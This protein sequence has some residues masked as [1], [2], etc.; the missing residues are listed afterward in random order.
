MLLIIKADLESKQG[1]ANGVNINSMLY[2]IFSNS[3]QSNDIC[4]HILW[5]KP[6]RNEEYLLRTVLKLKEVIIRSNAMLE[7]KY[8]DANSKPPS[9][10]WQIHW[11]LNVNTTLSR[12]TYTVA[13]VVSWPEWKKDIY[14]PCNIRLPWRCTSI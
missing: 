9:P 13:F 11:L 2:D 6:E 3:T 5:I 8:T 1:L 12:I 10:A 4:N 7:L 14:I